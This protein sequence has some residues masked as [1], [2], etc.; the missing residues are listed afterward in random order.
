MIQDAF[1]RVLESEF[2]FPFTNDQHT[3]AA[4]L[5]AFIMKPDARAAFILQGYAG[6]GKTTLVSALVRVMLKLKRNVILMAPTGRAAKVFSNH[7]SHPAYTI[8]KVIYRQK[9]KNDI[10]AG[11]TLDYNKHRNTLFLVDEASMI[12]NEGASQSLFGS[13]R[14]MDDLLEYVYSGQGCRIMLVG[15]TAQLPPV[16]EVESPALS[17]AMLEQWRLNVTL[18]SLKEVMRQAQQSGILSNATQLRH[19]IAENH[20]ITAPTVKVEGFPDLRITKGNNLIDALESSYDHVGLD[21]TIVITRSN[22]RAILYNNGIRASIFGREEGMTRGD[23]VMIARNNYYWT[24]KLAA[25]LPEGEQLPMDFIANGDI[26]VVRHI[27]RHQELYGL[28]FADVTLS[29]PDYN[30]LEMDV[31]VILDA[32]QSESP[33]LSEKLSNQLFQGVMED[34]AEYP[35][36]KKRMEKLREDPNYN[37]IQLKYAYA[38]TCHKAQGGQWQ[39]VFIDQGWIPDES[40]DTSYYRWLYTAFTRATEQLDL[41]NWPDKQVEQ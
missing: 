39:H 6:T 12:A 8:H 2:P 25:S 10:N 34:Y 26:A 14:L 22:K 5:S 38:V 29:F 31:R 33:S 3:A 18:T 11:F 32:L 4:E 23:I 9:S 28:H 40:V 17:K 27:S 15:D 20:T 30:D 37:A 7:A 16:G 35:T 36:Y 24:E 1:F 19:M 41:I 13:G 21:E